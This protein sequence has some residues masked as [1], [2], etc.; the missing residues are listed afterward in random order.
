VEVSTDALDGRGRDPVGNEEIGVE[1]QVR[2]VLL[3]GAE[4]LHQDR[5]VRD[6]PIEFR[7][8]QLVESAREGCSRE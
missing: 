5:A 8:T 1:R 7:C 3:D 4:R 6:Q 2:S